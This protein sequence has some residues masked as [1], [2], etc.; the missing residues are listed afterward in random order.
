ME[1]SLVAVVGPTASGKSDLAM[2]LAGLFG[3][4]IV[5]ADSR[6]IYKGMDIGTA[7]PSAN[8]Q[9]LTAHHCIDMVEPSERYSVH[10]YQKAAR[11]AVAGIIRRGRVP[12]LVGGSGL[13]LD[14]V[15]YDYV[16]EDEGGQVRDSLPEDLRALQQ[17]ADDRGYQVPEQIYMNA[18]HLR[19]YIARGG[20]SGARSKHTSALIIGVSVDFEVLK[21]RIVTRVEQMIASGFVQEVEGLLQKYG[22]D[23]PGF[24]APGYGPAID[25][26][27]SKISEQELFDL[28]VKND[29]QLAKRQMTWFKRNTD[30]NWVTSRDEA[31]QLLRAKFPLV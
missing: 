29:T 1:S 13:Y 2:Y 4:E 20:N 11:Q 18:R 25:Y 22:E 9:K 8:E 24:R 15:L 7:K 31:E 17:I 12:F 27:S 26:L 16:F 21:R 30:I 10:D 28:F 14:A 19:G 6:T 23:A 3:G 5:A